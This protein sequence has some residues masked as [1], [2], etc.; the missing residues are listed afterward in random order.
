MFI[1]FELSFFF[2]FFIPPGKLKFFLDHYYSMNTAFN[3]LLFLNLQFICF[4]HLIGV[5]TIS[6]HLFNMK[7][8]FAYIHICM[9]AILISINNIIL[10]H[11][12]NLQ[13]I[14]Y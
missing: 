7:Y 14:A 6:S 5:S 10:C 2:F 12:P 1:M 4:A 8:I 11:N 9:Y 13:H 3:I